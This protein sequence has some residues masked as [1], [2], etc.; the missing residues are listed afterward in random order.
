MSLICFS[1]PIFTH[2]QFRSNVSWVFNSNLTIFIFR[3]KSKNTKIPPHSPINKKSHLKEINSNYSKTQ[4]C[5]LPTHTTYY[6][7]PSL[8]GR[9]HDFS[10]GGITLCQS[11]GSHQ[12]VMLFLPPVVG[13]LLKKKLTKGGSWAP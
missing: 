5:E 7:S 11:E 10:K 13:C 3:I 1:R 4:P 8:Q 2:N 6:L 12:T 9:S